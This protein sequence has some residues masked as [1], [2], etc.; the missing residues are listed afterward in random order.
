MAT[1]TVCGSGD[2]LSMSKTVPSEPPSWPR[3]DACPIDIYIP[4]NMPYQYPYKLAK[5][6]T[7]YAT[8]RIRETCTTHIMDS[9][10]GNDDLTNEDVLD[11]AHKVDSDLVVAKDYLHDQAKTTESIHDFLDAYDAH[12][13]RA[14]P[15]IPLQPPHHK[16][17]QEV[18]G[19]G[20]YLLGGMMDWSGERVVAA[21]RRFRQEIGYGP[22]LHALGSGASPAL[23]RAVADNPQL[24][25]SVDCSTPDQCAIN[26][27]I[28]DLSLQQRPYKLPRGEGSST[29]RVALAKHLALVLN[30]AFA[31]ADASD[32][33]QQS[34]EAFA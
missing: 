2:E 18:P 20:A 31:F 26:G 27:K 9:G 21:L 23:V 22:Y 7:S 32:T 28:Y 16:H 3:V 33:T 13:C 8:P 12:E 4:S 15:L 24:V 6:E 34:M 14:T 10:I 30:D 11:S 17:Y 19:H 25:Q 29:S 1:A 5:P